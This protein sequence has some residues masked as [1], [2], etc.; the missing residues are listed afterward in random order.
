MAIR[1]SNL[2]L[3]L[4]EPEDSLPEHAARVLGVLASARF[5]IHAMS[6]RQGILGWPQTYPVVAKHAFTFLF[7]QAEFGMGCP[8]NVT[9]GAVSETPDAALARGKAEKDCQSKTAGVE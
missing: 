9:D 1:L 4:E 3:R 7:N 8:I 5:G 6:H 2:R